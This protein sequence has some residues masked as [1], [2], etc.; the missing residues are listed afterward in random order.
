MHAWRRRCWKIYQSKGKSALVR[1]G[2]PIA[3][4]TWSLRMR[5][6]LCQFHRP[7]VFY[8]CSDWPSFDIHD[9][10]L[11]AVETQLTSIR[12]GMEPHQ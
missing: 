10:M 6:I 5:T 1:F 7:V 4:E 3:P 8:C 12:F 11:L 9:V 2:F